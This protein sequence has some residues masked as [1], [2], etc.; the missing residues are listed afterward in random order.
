MEDRPRIA[1]IDRELAWLAKRMKAAKVVDPTAQ[2]DKARVWF[3][4]TV[5]I[6]AEDHTTIDRMHGIV[7][8]LRADFP[9][10]GLVLQAMLRRTTQDA[11]TFSGPGSRVRLCKGAYDEPATVAL[12]ERA[13]IS[14]AYVAAART[15]FGSTPST[16]S[17]GISGIG[18]R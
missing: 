2:P 5:T 15:L 13:E 8:Q 6:D 14:A 12:R 4:A 9:G 3:G 11:V 10:V 18:S 7:E 1:E 17:G 16:T